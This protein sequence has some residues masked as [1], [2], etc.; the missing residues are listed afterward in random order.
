MTGSL[1]LET[2]VVE[3]TETVTISEARPPAA[4]EITT[5][6]EVPVTTGT[7][8]AVEATAGTVVAG[9]EEETGHAAIAGTV[10]D[11]VV[12]GVVTETGAATA[13]VGAEVLTVVAA[14]TEE[15]TTI[16]VPPAVGQ[17]EVVVEGLDPSPRSPVLH[18]S[19]PEL[20]VVRFQCSALVSSPGQVW[21]LLT[22]RYHG[23]VTSRQLTSFHHPP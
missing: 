6:T 5:E 23:D 21:P 12:A 7:T 2:N 22:L 9:L 11:V 13:A 16:V 17:A 14:T 20:A 18:P 8:Q 15:A 3:A 4:T 19:L 10:I 1:K